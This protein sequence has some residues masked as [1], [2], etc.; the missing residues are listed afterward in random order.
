MANEVHRDIFPLEVRF[1]FFISFPCK[2]S[3]CTHFCFQQMML[4]HQHVAGLKNF[5]NRTPL[6]LD[7]VFILQSFNC[8]KLIL[9]SKLFSH[10]R[11]CVMSVIPRVTGVRRYPAFAG[12]RYSQISSIVTCPV[13]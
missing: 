5:E 13:L 11:R 8:T 10:V 4:K 2:K 1:L 3:P 12:I 6:E 7:L 9:R